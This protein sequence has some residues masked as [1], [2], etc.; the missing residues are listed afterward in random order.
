MEVV[1][2]Y[3]YFKV[4]RRHFRGGTEETRDKHQAV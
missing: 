2:A 3:R 4:L 1:V